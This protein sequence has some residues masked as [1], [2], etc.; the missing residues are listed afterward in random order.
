MVTTILVI[1]VCFFAAIVAILLNWPL[2]KASAPKG[3][4][5]DENIDKLRSD[6]ELSLVRLAG[7][8]DKM[9]HLYNL[10][11]SLKAK[12]AAAPSP[13]EDNTPV[14]PSGEEREA[15][16]QESIERALRYL[17]YQYEIIGEGED[18]RI[19]FFKEG[20]R[21]DLH[22]TRIPFIGIGAFYQI[23]S[24]EDD[25]R[26]MKQ[27]AHQM[28]EQIMVA[29]AYVMEDNVLICTEYL[30]S[31]FEDFI[32]HFSRYLDL[33]IRGKQFLFS[34]YD[35][36]K[37]GDARNPSDTF[38]VPITPPAPNSGRPLS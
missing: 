23:S 33:I 32:D 22:F 4:S 7:L 9:N 27:A 12:A 16:N 10:G 28:C 37:E 15:L 11:E 5:R 25:I 31:S 29:K 6:M 1:S 3:P 21:M 30:C 2:K 17:G 13:G 8:E 24:D 18:R 26:L 35:K 34:I 14:E 38:P 19:S 20:D 36:L